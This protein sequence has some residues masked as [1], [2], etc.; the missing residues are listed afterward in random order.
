MV[1]FA[2]YIL[3]EKDFYKKIELAYYLHKKKNTFFNNSVIFKYFSENLQTLLINLFTLL[4]V[5][6]LWP[7]VLNLWRKK[8]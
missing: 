8:K 7:A 2:E 3:K 5:T 4:T 1:T 6:A